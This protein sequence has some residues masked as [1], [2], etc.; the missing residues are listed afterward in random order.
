MAVTKRRRK[1]VY[2]HRR[3]WYHVSTTLENDKM[4]LIPWDGPNAVNRDPTEPPGKRIC[5][6]PTVEQCLVAIPYHFGATVSIYRTR[7]KVIA[8]K[9]KDVFDAS[10]T[11]EG[12][13]TRPISFIKIGSLDFEHIEQKL[14]IAHVIKEVASLGSIPDSRKGLRWWKHV[15][16]KRFIKT[17]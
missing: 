14:K 1:D 15:R 8:K 12:W 17:A 5:V 9:P 10:I 13:L 3:Y 16:I 11:D 6:A 2:S 7:N 4:T